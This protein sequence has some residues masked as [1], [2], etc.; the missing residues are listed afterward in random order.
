MSAL[1]FPAPQA[2]SEL[3]AELDGLTMLDLLD[4]YTHVRTRKFI[5]Y[6]PFLEALLVM[7]NSMRVPVSDGSGA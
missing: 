2:C 5:M 4:A 1:I 6:Q 3:L 7:L